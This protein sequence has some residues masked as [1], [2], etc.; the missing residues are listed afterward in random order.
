MTI[1]QLLVTHRSF[2]R[3]FERAVVRR[4]R[5]IKKVMAAQL[6]ARK[7]M[8][9]PNKSSTKASIA[10]KHK[11]YNTI[12][13]SVMNKASNSKCARMHQNKTGWW[14]GPSRAMKRR[15]RA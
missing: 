11:L 4:R 10:L 14:V 15:C 13:R 5:D 9:N 7:A 3:E 2:M 6:E 8:R 1:K 12:Y